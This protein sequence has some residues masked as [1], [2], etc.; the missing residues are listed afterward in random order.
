MWP[1]LA[2]AGA[3]TLE[4]VDA[5]T[6]QPVP[7]RVQ[8]RDATGKDHAPPDALTMKIGEPAM[9]FVSP[10]RSELAVPA[11]PTELRVER[12]TEYRPI[13][14]TITVA[15][16][17]PQTERV[18]L[19]RWTDMR[20]RGYVSGENHLHVACDA[21]G[22]MLAAED[23]D[24]GTSLQ[25]WNA[26]TLEV[27]PGQGWTRVLAFAGA[28]TPTS[29]YDYEIENAWGAVYVV[30]QRTPLKADRGRGR[31]NLPLLQAS[32]QAGALV[33][34]QG[35]WSREVLVDAL[36]GCVDVVNLCNNNFHPHWYQPRSRYSNLLDVEG[37][38]V[39]PDTPQGM[40]DL[41]LETYYRLLNCG[42]RLAA[43]AGSATGPKLTPVGFN[44]A[45]VRAGD[46]PGLPDFYDAWRAGRNFVTNGPM[47]FLTVNGEHRPGD[48]IA[49]PAS[50]GALKV[51]VE[52][53]SDQPFTSLAIVKNGQVIAESLS[54]KLRQQGLTAEFQ[55]SDGAWIAARCT[56]E[57]RL[58]S[59]QELAAYSWHESM[60]RR[61]S[62]LRFAHTSP[63]YV[64]VG[65]RGAR[66][67]A[68]LDE[69]RRMLDA[70]QRFARKESDPEHL[71][72]ALHAV[73]AART[74]LEALA[75]Q[76]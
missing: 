12:G 27:P 20:Q 63:V 75:G 46:E 57:D 65:G 37:F 35:G 2:N 58:L 9:W 48:T 11:G 60:P 1:A 5:A 62:R 33:C 43:G 4:I 69:A 59:D 76:R 51:R 66:V 47:L 18:L 44:R 61:P 17:G 64:T 42:L 22:P 13:K 52:A 14:R 70:F 21:L 19:E 24:F 71:D 50:G 34:Y 68:S 49:L 40:L 32:H 53:V 38:P 16:T 3:L 23:L 74:R 6:K 29:V 30:G 7:A 10:G 67:A 26:E 39:Y 31:M 25:W 36:L 15:D 72:A 45:Y 28:K 55:V 8:V 54:R 41:N 56:A 73:A